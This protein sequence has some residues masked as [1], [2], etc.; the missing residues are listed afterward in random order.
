MVIIG[1]AFQNIII[2]VAVAIWFVDC[3]LTAVLRDLKV[4]Q[5]ALGNSSSVRFK[6]KV[7]AG[8]QCE[9]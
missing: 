6:T 8:K 9:L 1:F 2:F 3:Q 5:L 7:S 4:L